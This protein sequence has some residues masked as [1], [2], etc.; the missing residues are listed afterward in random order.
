MRYREALA[1]GARERDWS[2]LDG[3]DWSELLGYLPQFAAKC[4]WWKLKG[5]NWSYLL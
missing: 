3:T 4:D 1:V 5:Q 2:K